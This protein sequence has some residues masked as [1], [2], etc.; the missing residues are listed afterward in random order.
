M[1]VPKTRRRR[2]PR[3][4]ALA[5][6][7]ALVAGGVTL[8]LGHLRQGAPVVDRA[9][10]VI[11]VVHRGQMLRQVRGQGTLVPTDIR[12]VTADSAARVERIRVVAGDAVT[13]GTVLVE[14]SNPD[15][16]LRALE[17]DREL[18]EARA[19]LAE[20]EA[21]LDGQRLAQESGVAAIEGDLAD[22]TRR[23]RTLSQLHAD[24]AA[25]ALESDEALGR[26]ETLSART[27]F[28]KRRLTAI[29]RSSRAQIAAQRSQVAGLEHL[30][31]FAHRQVAA[32]TVTAASP[33]VVQE[34]P[35]ES[36]QM[37]AAGALLCK[38]VDPT[39]LKAELRVPETQI[40]DVAVGLAATVELGGGAGVATVPGHVSRIDPAA[41]AGTIK[42]DVAL[43]GRPPAGARPDLTVDGVV[44][45]ERLDQVLFVDRPAF[46]GTSD[47]ISLFRVS[48]G[49][50]EA[51]RVPVEL[52]KHSVATVQVRAG[53]REGES[54]ILSD[55]GQLDGAD[56][57]R[58]Q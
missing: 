18:G 15:V 47:R 43:D 32:L 37:V 29:A 26:A 23:A 53:L 54:V 56:R 6:V 21:T 48:P 3:R 11:G 39:R 27:A 28:E 4:I 36:G 55:L 49:G 20:L 41:V 45:I 34:L 30:A 22:A 9:T 40:K 10:V 57:I 44:E 5:A 35:L 50:D 14:L 46:A 12:L 38:L 58:L 25:S 31:D 33:G 1:D 2:L 7:V 52:G 13:P 24:G 19:H 42:I 51:V 8:G 16:E 17:A